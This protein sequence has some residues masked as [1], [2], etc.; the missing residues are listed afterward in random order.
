[1]PDGL[2]LC[3]YSPVFPLK[4]C[5]YMP[6][7]PASQSPFTTCCAEPRLLSVFLAINIHPTPLFTRLPLLIPSFS[8]LV[9]LVAESPFYWACNIGIF[10]GTLSLM[11]FG[12]SSW[13]SF[14]Q[15]CLILSKP[16]IPLEPEIFFN[17]KHL[18][19]RIYLDFEDY[20]LFAK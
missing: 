8:S 20:S 2:F 19:K 17:L 6:R 16:Q 12:L 7:R 4:D 18:F 5:I 1:M 10:L 9:V 11:H 14:S 3:A 15:S 13:S